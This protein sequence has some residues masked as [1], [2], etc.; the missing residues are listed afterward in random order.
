MRIK[1]AQ[2]QSRNQP[3]VEELRSRAEPGRVS[4][5]NPLEMCVQL[6][7]NQA[8]NL[9]KKEKLIASWPVGST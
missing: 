5:R 8:E 3:Q 4:P 7:E 6:Q 2:N 1:L 9:R